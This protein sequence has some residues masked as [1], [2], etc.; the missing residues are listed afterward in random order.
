MAEWTIRDYQRQSTDSQGKS[1]L[2]NEIL[3]W[4]LSQPKKAQ[5]KIDTIILMLQAWPPPWPA[6]YISS[7]KGRPDILEVIIKCQGVQYRPLG[8]YGLGD[9]VFTLLIGAVEKNGKIA[10]GILDSA[11][12]RRKKVLKEGWPTREHEYATTAS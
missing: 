1:V 5:A 3:E 6:Q 10:V 9:R 4:T 8:C 7:Y 11:E 12:G 2:V